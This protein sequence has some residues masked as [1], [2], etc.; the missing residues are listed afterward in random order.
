M[1]IRK[2][3]SIYFSLTALFSALFVGL[4]LFFTIET[5]WYD[6]LLATTIFMIPTSLFIILTCCLVGA[7]TGSII[8]A[9]ILHQ[10][11]QVAEKLLEIEKGVY[12][13]VNISEKAKDDFSEIWKRVDHLSAKF[14]EQALVNQKLANQKVEWNQRQEK[15]VLTKER[16]RLARELHDSVSQQLFAAT[17][18]LSAINQ[19]P[20]PLSETVR[21]QKKLVEEIIN[22]AQSEMRALLLHL[23][24]VQLEGKSLKHGMEEML[25]ELTSRLALEVVWNI[26]DVKLEKAMEDHLF[27][28]VQEGV[29]NTLRHA[30]ATILEVNLKQ[31]GQMVYL[32]IHDNGRGFD[33]EKQKAG[34]LGLTSIKER[35]AEIGGNVKMMSILGK[36]ST[37]EVQVPYISGGVDSK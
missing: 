34:S 21:K 36:G 16:N 32:K 11:K 37:V 15:E 1:K 9:M 27:R 2:S 10:N 20:D 12:E 29:S 3:F 31:I 24:P 8:G 22:E 25:T 28:I 35:T 17:M 7:I 33:V 13:P 23:R 19:N 18:L 26:Q 6:A 5:N 14:K 4:I 30:K